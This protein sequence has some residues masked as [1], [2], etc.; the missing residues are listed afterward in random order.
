[1][2]TPHGKPKER[3]AFVSRLGGIVQLAGAPR[4]PR[5][6]PKDAGANRRSFSSHSSLAMQWGDKFQGFTALAEAE[7]RAPPVAETG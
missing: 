2:V 4:S 3:A 7:A 5:V 1:M 6:P